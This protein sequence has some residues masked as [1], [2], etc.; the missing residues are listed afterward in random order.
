MRIA[1]MATLLGLGATAAAAQDA[2]LDPAGGTVALT[3]GFADDP[4][5]TD[6]TAG[7]NI[8]AASIDS[9]CSGYI[10]AAPNFRLSY[11]GS[12]AELIISIVANDDTTLVVSDPAGGWYCND[13]A[14][15]QNPAV[16]LAEPPQGEY[17]IWVGVRSVGATAAARLYFS[18][19]GT[20]PQY[21]AFLALNTPTSTP[22]HTLAPTFGEVSL[23]AGFTPDPY[24][25][26]VTSGGPINPGALGPF[27]DGFISDA[28]VVGL[29]FTAGTAPLIIA[30][31]SDYD[32]TLV[33]RDPE[34]NWLCDDDSGGSLNPLVAIQSPVS[35]R[36]DIWVGTYGET[37]GQETE[38]RITENPG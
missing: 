9:S 37:A 33:I 8:D 36:Y 15:D 34:G 26:N 5:V 12:G 27:C 17:N 4:F 19:Y 10:S 38:L 35:G 23:V 14:G 24:I 3:A 21:L 20:G 7:G 29:D 30:A 6:V 1:L 32:T 16:A 28:P 2:T 31:T 25:V 11:D 13:N 22:D 18:A